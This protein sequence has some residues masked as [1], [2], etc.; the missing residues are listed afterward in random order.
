MGAGGGRGGGGEKGRNDNG[1][2]NSNGLEHEFRKKS[3][4]SADSPTSLF[5][6]RKK[7]IKKLII[8]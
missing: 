8:Q 2:G 3:Q 5:N 6:N 7:N 1:R 4:S